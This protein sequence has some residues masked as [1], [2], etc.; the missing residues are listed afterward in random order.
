MIPEQYKQQIL[1]SIRNYTYTNNIRIKI[2]TCS[3]VLCKDVKFDHHC[4]QRPLKCSVFSLYIGH[5]ED[6]VVRKGYNGHFGLLSRSDLN[7]F[8]FAYI[9][10]SSPKG[11]ESNGRCS[12]FLVVEIAGNFCLYFF[13]IS[14][15][16]ENTIC[17]NESNINA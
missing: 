10:S 6:M 12:N 16:S 2:I 14:T 5:E 11:R 15:A 4:L 13:A 8:Q 9:F 3:L 1:H 17:H 7:Q